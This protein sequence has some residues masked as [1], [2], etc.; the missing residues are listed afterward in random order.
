[1]VRN[2]HG[3]AAIEYRRQKVRYVPL[4]GDP[5]EYLP[6]VAAMQ[7]AG[8]A[9]ADGFA[10]DEQWFDAT[11]DHLYPDAPRRIWDAFHGT[12]THPPE[13]MITTED[14]FC[15][16]RSGFEMFIQMASTHGSLNQVNSATFVMSMTDR[17]Q[18]PMRTGD[19]LKVI[20]P[21]WSASRVR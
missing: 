10:S 8:K 9:D 17:V 16:G 20:E 14:G 4:E 19:I 15:A 3:L 21:A 7:S 2:A 18:H 5:L 13:V 6:T 1:M 12:V 11:L